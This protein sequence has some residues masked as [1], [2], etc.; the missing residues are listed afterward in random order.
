MSLV[1][2]V[3]LMGILPVI[4]NTLAPLGIVGSISLLGAGVMLTLVSNFRTA[5]YSWDNKEEI[6]KQNKVCG[7]LAKKAFKAS[8]ITL[9]L[10]L[11]AALI[12]SEKTMYTMAAVYAGQKIAETP[13]AQQIGNDAFDVLKGILAKAKRELAEETPKK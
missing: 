2:I 4:A 12:P 1:F 7:S 11:I 13:E 8:I 6:E 9:T 3:Y 5:T 10:G